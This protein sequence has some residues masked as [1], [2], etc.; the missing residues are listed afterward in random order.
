MVVKDPEEIGRADVA[1][2]VEYGRH[3]A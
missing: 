1:D 2:R 3:L